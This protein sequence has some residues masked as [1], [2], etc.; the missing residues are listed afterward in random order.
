MAEHFLSIPI[1]R[2]TPRNV[3]VYRN[4]KMTIFPHKHQMHISVT[5]GKVSRFICR[6]LSITFHFSSSVLVIGNVYSLSFKLKRSVIYHWTA[7]FFLT[8]LYLKQGIG[9]VYV[10]VDFICMG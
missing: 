2:M 10:M 6:T 1:I 4:A 9:K 5:N 7:Y 8:K 3:T